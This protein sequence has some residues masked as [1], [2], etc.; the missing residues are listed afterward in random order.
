MADGR[1]IENGLLAIY[2][3]II[4]RLTRNFVV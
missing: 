4:T 2:H 1:R 3:R